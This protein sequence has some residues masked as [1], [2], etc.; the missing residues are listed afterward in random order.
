MVTAHNFT[1][2]GDPGTINDVCVTGGVCKGTPTTCGNLQALY[3]D[4]PSGFAVR[5]DTVGDERDGW[6]GGGKGSSLSPHKICG[7]EYVACNQGL[8]VGVY[9]R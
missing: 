2:A 6:G 7:L 4:C 1:L 9:V 3:S 8:A 5:T